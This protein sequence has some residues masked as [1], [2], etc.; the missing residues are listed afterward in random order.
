[1]GIFKALKPFGMS[2]SAKC[3]TRRTGLGTINMATA[4]FTSLDNHSKDVEFMYLSLEL[5][6]KVFTEK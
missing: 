5:S 6:E 3:N 4:Y 2:R 1:M